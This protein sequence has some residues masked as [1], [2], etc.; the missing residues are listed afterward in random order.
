LK[1]REGVYFMSYM[2]LEIYNIAHQLV[3]DIHKM[4]LKE[5]PKFEM[6]EEGSQI[7]K[8]SKSVKSNIVEEYGRR[9]YK[10]EFIK[11]LTYAIASNDETYDHLENLFQTE[12]LKNA[13]LYKDLVDGLEKL[14]KKL[15]IFSQT[16]IKYHLPVK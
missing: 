13:E 7:R 2:K 15:N 5:L 11:F 9:R 1:K 16:V 14:G 8:S 3:L 4:T 12:S 10:K 6:F